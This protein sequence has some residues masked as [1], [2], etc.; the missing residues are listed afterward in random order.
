MAEQM[1]MPQRQSRQSKRRRTQ[2]TEQHQTDIDHGE[3]ERLAQLDAALDEYL[4]QTLADNDTATVGLPQ[5]HLRTQPLSNET[6]VRGFRQ[7]IGE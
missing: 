6:L 7:T 1:Q 3:R 5:A 2:Q 4:T